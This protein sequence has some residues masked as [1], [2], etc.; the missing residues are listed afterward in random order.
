MRLTVVI[1]ILFFSLNGLF[2][3]VGIKLGVHSFDLSSPKDII[4]PSEEVISFSD[5]KLGFQAGIYGRID[6]STVFIEPRVMLHSTQV[7]YTLSGSNGTLTNALRSESFTNLDIPIMVG[8]EILFFDIYLGPVAHFNLGST[9]D[10]FDI[11]GYETNFDTVDFGWRGGLHFGLGQVGIDLE[12][13][14]NLSEF[15]KHI[16]VD[17]ESYTFNNNPSRLIL[18]LQIQ[19]F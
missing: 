1:T 19:L 2:A 9:S 5:S 7:E 3:Q 8:T 10:L 11:A 15:G 14:G 12:Y 18:N 17:N 13:E 16:K 4:L 6:L